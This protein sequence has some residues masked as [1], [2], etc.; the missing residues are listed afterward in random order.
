MG[1]PDLFGV[2]DWS[3]M[4]DT[5]LVSEI[6]GPTLQGEGPTAGLPTMFLRLGLC[7]LSCSW[8]DTPYTWDWTGK[9]GTVYVKGEQT[10]RM[11]V[12]DVAAAVASDARR[13]VITGGEPLLQQAALA[14][15]DDFMLRQRCAVEVETNGTIVPDA[16]LV[17]WRWNVSPKLSNSGDPAEQRTRPRA[18]E[19]FVAWQR[20]GAEVTFKFVV[21]DEHDLSEVDTMVEAYGM[22]NVWLMP[23]GRDAETIVE[24]L[25]ELVPLAVER[26]YR[27]TPRLHVLA[28]GDRRG[29]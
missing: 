27:V 28:Y 23:E 24:R 2:V 9:N 11:P 14:T 15:L 26:G 8:C 19:T 18:L 3:G 13:L 6:F 10:C 22:A 25:G 29:V 4:K 21:R 5:L 20:R 16:Q 12:K 7:N 17:A 1:D